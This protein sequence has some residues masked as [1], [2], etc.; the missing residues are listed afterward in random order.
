MMIF[1]VENPRVGSSILPPA[2]SIYKGLA[3]ARPFLFGERDKN[4][5]N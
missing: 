4:V 1:K 3:F 5:T 2:T